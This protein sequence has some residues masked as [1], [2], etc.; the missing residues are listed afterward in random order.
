MLGSNMSVAVG[1]GDASRTS[2]ELA[3]GTGY[4]NR[5]ADRR[6]CSRRRPLFVLRLV[7]RK[8]RFLLDTA[9]QQDPR[10]VGVLVKHGRE[11]V[12]DPDRVGADPVGQRG[13]FRKQRYRW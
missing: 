9:S 1:G 12:L 2:E 10:A 11:E 5:G 3:C 6:L 13:G 4:A 8:N 7:Q